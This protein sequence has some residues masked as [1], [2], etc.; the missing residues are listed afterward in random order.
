MKIHALIMAGGKGTRLE[1]G[2]E[3]LLLVL[4]GK[5]LIDY[6]LE[7]VAGC[8]YID[9]FWAVTSPH[10]PKIEEHLRE[11]SIQI[12]HAPGDGYVED[13]VF[14]IKELGIG[15]TLTI[16]ADLPLVRSGDLEWVIDEYQRQYNPALAVNTAIGKDLIP[17]GVNIVDGK[18]LNGSE[19]NLITAKP[20]FGLNV[21]TKE[22]LVEA[23]RRIRNVN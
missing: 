14:A 19:F 15:K 5:F 18:N 22:E 1:G 10:T 23:Q 11:K 13:L 17:T 16:T 4:E 8:K 7:A 3:K 6:T 9:K 12:L 21:N 2:T 20:Q